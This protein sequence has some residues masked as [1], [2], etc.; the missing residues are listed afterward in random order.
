MA[1]IV[2]PKKF[3]KIIKKDQNLEGI[4]KKTAAD[5]A[6]ILIENNLYFFEEYT[7]HGINHIESVL[8]GSDR[9]ITDY[10]YKI[11]DSKNIS[12]YI[13]SVILHDIGMHVSYEGLKV[14]LDGEHDDI[15][16]TSFDSL[17]W[18]EA[19]LEYISE[20]KRFSG[21][22]LIS[23][24]GDDEVI[25]RDPFKF[26]KGEITGNDKKLIGEFV[27][28]Y[29]PRLAH[30]IALVGFP[31]NK[32]G[33]IK[34][35]E[36]LSEKEKNLVGLIARSHG[37]NLR[38]CLEYL[39][40]EFK[41]LK[42]TPL[43]V[44]ASYLM[45][46]LR[47]SD[48]LQ[49]Q[50][51]RTSEIILKTKT[52]ESPISNEEHK[53]HLAVEY[54]DDRYQD[55]PERIFVSTSPQNSGMYLKLKRLFSSIQNEFDISWA[56]LGELYGNLDDSVSIKYRR[57]NS[58]LDDKAYISEQNYIGDYFSF[59]ANDEITRLLIAPLY[60]N[61]PKYGVRELLQNSVDACNERLEIE[62][63]NPNYFPEIKINV[64]NNNEECFFQIS[65]NGK[66][67]NINEIKN[68]FLSAGA[69]YRQSKDWKKM[70]M[71]EKGN[72]KIL[73]NGRFGIGVLASFL[74][75][76]SIIVKT[77]SF[78]SNIG[79]VFEANL[80]SNQINV[81]K[82]DKLDT[83]TTIS[84][85]IS[86]EIYDKFNS[87]TKGY[88][89][90]VLWYEWFTLK[91]PKINYQFEDITV[92][93]YENL[94]PHYLYDQLPDDW[95]EIDATGYDKIR[96]TY[97]ENYSNNK[98]VC[99]GIVIP[100]ED[101]RDYNQ[102]IID[103]RHIRI[104]PNILVFDSNGLSPISLNRNELTD[105]FSFDKELL[106][107]LYKDLI[108]YV[109]TFD[110]LSYVDGQTI[111]IKN[112]GL[113]HPAF[114]GQEY[115]YGSNNNLTN[116]YGEAIY[117]TDDYGSNNVDE[118]LISKKGYILNY[119][120]FVK[121]L[122]NRNLIFMQKKNYEG[123]LNLDIKDNFIAITKD[124]SSSIDYY[125]SSLMK[126]N[127]GRWQPKYKE[128]KHFAFYDNF[129]TWAYMKKSKFEFLFRDSNKRRMPQ[130]LNNMITIERTLNKSNWCI[131]KL[132]VPEFKNF[133]PNSFLNENRNEINFIRVSPLE[134]QTEGDEILNSLLERYL[135]EDIIIPYD[136][137]K[138]K[139]KYPLAFKE[140]KRYMK[141]YI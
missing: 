59:K 118:I 110:D 20:A 33:S 21:K 50:K 112:Q 60:G 91:I 30:E 133:I 138:R 29:H 16:I 7:D 45:I 35:A 3:D 81:T 43:G 96:W 12:F 67:M 124:N 47:L 24:F 135:G 122:K 78:N 84:I 46:L 83:G 94:D 126:N 51:D 19:W 114:H 64:F 136:I 109:L 102:K 117:D 108:A 62:Q 103:F 137:E 119:N 34:F 53:T 49:I 68:Y 79:Y 86:Q 48:Y 140:L 129:D 123:K 40:S 116:M 26:K 27:R 89:D 6:E 134:C 71:D 113:K 74:I 14:L 76:K 111:F 75:G 100:Y 72:S 115:Y 92:E 15:L 54:I 121:K 56:V 38:D 32:K 87:K 66:G 127:Y 31:G 104:K 2:L 128:R 101:S 18:S 105:A 70:F 44:H 4:I 28:R 80:N 82:D 8:F 90:N 95:N 61:N 25:I 37:M 120:F 99:N 17:T 98:L 41:N 55:D 36:E 9:L 131:L 13:L 77:K 132:G 88:N 69:S 65:D 39:E 11:L 73:R 10:T 97:S 85:K 107:S 52:F 58:N 23:I 125:K 63:N 130:W 22:Q 57:I 139:E 42:R 5:F 1:D 93:P 106:V 141:N